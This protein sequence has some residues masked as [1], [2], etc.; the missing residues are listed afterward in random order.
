[1]E[2]LLEINYVALK[3]KGST[4]YVDV[5][6][7]NLGTK[8]DPKYVKLSSSLSKE[9]RAEYVNLLREFA[10]VFSWKYEDLMTYDTNIIEH[11]IT[12]K[13]DTNPFS[14]KHKQI[15]PMLLPITKN[16]VKKLLDA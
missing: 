16:E 6:E 14:K 15:N 10:Y 9:K 12:L 7:L 2:R 5:S 1:L 11:K 3:I 4:E 13:E 8:E